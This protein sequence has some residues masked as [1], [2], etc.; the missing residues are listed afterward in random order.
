MTTATT[1]EV[2]ASVATGTAVPFRL[3]AVVVPV[4]DYDRAKDFYV[5][6]GWRVDADVDGAEGYRLMQ[7]TPPGSGAS[8]I[9]GTRVTSAE[10]GSLD[11]LLL[12]VD[13]IDAA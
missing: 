3:E 6:L 7:V 8:V 11:G 1:H 9:F 12:V 5:G 4:S 10:P 13:D 2:Q